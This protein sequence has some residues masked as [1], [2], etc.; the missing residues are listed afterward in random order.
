M[1]YWRLY[2][3]LVWTTKKRLPLLTPEVERW[4]FP[5]LHDKVEAIGGSL[6]AVNGC[7]DHIH[8]AASIPPKM[9][10]SEFVKSLKGSSSFDIKK[11]TITNNYFAWQE[12]YSVFTISEKVLDRVVTYIKNQKEHHQNETT[13]SLY[14][15]VSDL[16]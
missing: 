16:P 13:I 6:Y 2:Y 14:E 7:L 8:I 15:P 11:L 9:S 3:H 12:S 5:Y 4:L 10:I 1:P